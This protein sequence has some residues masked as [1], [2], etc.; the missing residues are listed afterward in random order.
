M[1]FLIAL[2][3]FTFVFQIYALD[4]DRLKN[5][6][7]SGLYSELLDH[8]AGLQNNPEAD[9]T[10]ALFRGMTFYKMNNF[11]ESRKLLFTI[12]QRS[13]N[14]FIKENALYYLALSKIRTEEMVEGAVI[15]TGLLNSAQSDISDNSRTILETLINYKFNEDDFKDLTDNT[16]DKSVVKFINQSMNS[17]K[18][19]AVLP[20]SG[21]DK[22]AGRDL[23][24]GLEFA[25]KGLNLKGKKIKLD[26]VN[27][28]GKIPVMTKKVLERLNSSRY[29]L[30]IGELRSDA[31]AALAGIATLKSIPLISPT[32]SANEISD[33]SKYVFQ[34]NTTSYSLGKMIAEYAVDSLN[35][36][37]FAILAPATEDGDESVSG[38]AE[39]I[40]E[41]GCAVISTEWYFET[42]DLNKQLQR[43]REKIL[44]ISSLDKE[45]Y[46][47]ADSI[48]TF[49]AGIIDA[50]FLPVPNSD[51]ESVLSQVSYYNFKANVLGTYG[52][53]DIKMLNKFS[54]NADS[55]VF[56]KES[57]YDTENPKFN[58]FVFSFRKEMNRN[59]K[60]LE[61]SGYSLIEMLV[62]IQA[63]TPE[64]SILK[65][66][67]DF[68]EYNSISG[69]MILKNKRSN[70][71][72][73][74]F[75]FSAKKGL[76]KVS[77]QEITKKDSLEV[78]EKFFNTGFVNEVTANYDKA[79]ENYLLSLSDLKK[80][81]NISDSLF[82]SDTRTL[83]V[84]LRLGYSYLMLNDNKN[85]II[86]FEEFLKYDPENK[87][88]IF[89]NAVAAAVDDPEKSI[90]ILSKYLTDKQYS[91]EANLEIGNIYRSLSNKTKA[92]EYYDK[93][94]KLRNKKAKKMIKM[95]K[96][97]DNSD[98]K[99]T[100]NN[101]K[102]KINF[103]W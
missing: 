60:N 59:P 44:E 72:S 38:F 89:K 98:E 33:I 62:S 17:L 71:S 66:L 45:E 65:I 79:V 78:S 56:I 54:A 70:S 94:A 77:Y 35:Y 27:S 69:K 82:N 18:I 61:I 37:T 7:E 23:L 9:F 40:V 55:L 97:M 68:D 43:I 52:W 8:T 14:T 74:I 3:F 51:I 12:S 31:T 103:D 41:K 5:L 58:D 46:M 84:K 2:I 28:E 90:N 75:K 21:A 50:V 73:E 29:N 4:I 24:S 49:Q 39:K 87:D 53:N 96:N 13:D 93:A 91:S 26:V 88:V 80:V 6:Y 47:S 64:R 63:E 101:T 95:V 99:K 25:V 100:I 30:I 102:N 85:A 81:L 11:R 16:F 22:D 83:R 67:S 1:K 19:L 10:S 76:D 20:L 32:A 57:S 15:L 48:R 92:L 86:C 36:K 34:L 42:F